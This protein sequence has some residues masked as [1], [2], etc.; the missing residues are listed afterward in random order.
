MNIFIF[1]RAAVLNLI[2]NILNLHDQRNFENVKQYSVTNYQTQM[3]Y[4][5]YI[6]V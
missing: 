4:L 3:K 1:E 2:G 5:P 6:T